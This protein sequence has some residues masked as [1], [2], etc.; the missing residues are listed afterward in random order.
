MENNGGVLRGEVGKED[1]E[2]DWDLLI[3]RVISKGE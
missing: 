3:C 2:R 1:E